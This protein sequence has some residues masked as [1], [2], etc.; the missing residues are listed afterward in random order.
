MDVSGIY[1]PPLEKMSL[2]SWTERTPCRMCAD[3]TEM[4]A[5]VV[6]LEDV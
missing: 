4:G 3:G 1:G 2:P 6:G 5:V